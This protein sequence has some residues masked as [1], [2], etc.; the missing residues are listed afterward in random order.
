[1]NLSLVAYQLCNYDFH[2]VFH[3]L[4]CFGSN[5]NLFAA[6]LLN[7]HVP[8]L[9]SRFFPHRFIRGLDWQIEQEYF[10]VG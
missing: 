6:T 9:V 5:K 3:Q 4:T 2:T 10:A 1:M 8:L 7:A